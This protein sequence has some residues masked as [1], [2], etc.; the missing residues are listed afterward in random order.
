MEEDLQKLL[1]GLQALTEGDGPTLDAF[2]SRDA[3]ELLRER[4]TAPISEDDR[5]RYEVHPL[6][7]TSL[8][9]L[10]NTVSKHLNAWVRSHAWRDAGA[11]CAAL[12]SARRTSR[13][14]S[15]SAIWT[16]SGPRF[17]PPDLTR[18][19]RVA[20]RVTDSTAS[21]AGRRGGSSARL[22]RARVC[23]GADLA[24]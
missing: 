14:R 13:P 9:Q 22:A 7:D 6:D 3:A 21:F 18:I 17:A 2:V 8:D 4:G 1:Q 12:Q 5:V 10:Q 16:T 24:R 15:R 20:C 11:P 19:E 23:G